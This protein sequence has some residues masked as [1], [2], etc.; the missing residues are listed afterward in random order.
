VFFVMEVGTRH[1]HVLGVTGNPDGAWTAQQARNLMMDLGERATQFR[2]L[3]R[4]RAGQFT[5]AFD[6]VLSAAGSR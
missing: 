5:G 4:D 2:F 6:A 3:I 1:V